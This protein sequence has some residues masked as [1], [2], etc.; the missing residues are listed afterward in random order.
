MRWQDERQSDNVEDRRGVSAGQV[1]IGGGIGTILI[2]LIMSFLTGEDPRALMQRMR[3]PAGRAAKQLV[4]G[5]VQ[6]SPEEQRQADLVKATLAMTEDVWNEIFAKAGRKY[7]NPFG[8]LFEPGEDRW[9]RP[10]RHGGRS[11]LLPG[12]SE[13]LH[14]PGL[15]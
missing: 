10:G 1:A 11:V 12:R 2:V 8:S 6:L 15:L 13:G 5:P 9:L 3:H 14:R 7:Q 4:G